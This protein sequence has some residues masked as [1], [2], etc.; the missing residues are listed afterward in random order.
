MFTSHH[1]TSYVPR[2]P[3][4]IMST[5]HL[6]MQSYILMYILT[7]ACI[8]T[9]P[10]DPTHPS[11]CVLQAA[12]SIRLPRMTVPLPMQVVLHLG[13]VSRGTVR[14]GKGIT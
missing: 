11:C 14:T 13:P 5:S 7:H 10:H 12:A 4:M 2:Q 9:N 8:L 6:L 1:I 3:C